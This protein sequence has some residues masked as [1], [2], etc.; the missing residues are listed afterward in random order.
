MCY[1][2]CLPSSTLY[3]EFLSLPLPLSKGKGKPIKP[4]LPTLLVEKKGKQEPKQIASGSAVNFRCWSEATGW[5]HGCEQRERTKIKSCFLATYFVFFDKQITNCQVQKASF[6]FLPYALG[7]TWGYSIDFDTES[8]QRV[9]S[10]GHFLL[11]LY[12]V[13][14][15]W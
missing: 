8:M 10:N 6:F 4:P 5:N 14:S 9:V 1:G 3:R 12:R 15:P 11:N 7:N 2:G 13:Q